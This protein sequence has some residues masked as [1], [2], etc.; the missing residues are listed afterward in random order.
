[1]TNNFNDNDLYQYPPFNQHYPD[2]IWNRDSEYLIPVISSVGNG[3]K[4]DKGDP[5]N[6]DDLTD[7]QLGKIYRAIGYRKLDGVYT[8][9]SVPAREIPIPVT[10]GY[11]PYDV[12]FVDVNGL[13]LVEGVDYSISGDNIVLANDDVITHVGTRVH[14]R[15][16]RFNWT[17][18]EF[19]KSARAYSTVAD[20]I[21]DEGL[22][23][24]SICHTNGFYSSGDGGASWYLVSS[25]ATE[26]GTDVIKLD[27]GLRAVLQPKEYITPEQLGVI[28][29]SDTIDSWDGSSYTYNQSTVVEYDEKIYVARV[30]VPQGVSINNHNYWVRCVNVEKLSGVVGDLSTEL[31]QEIE[32]REAAV[33][34]E[35]Q[36]RENAISEITEKMEADYS[37][38]SVLTANV[39]GEFDC[40]QGIGLDGHI[41]GICE[42]SNGDIV[43]IGSKINATNGEGFWRRVNIT[44][45]KD[46]YDSANYGLNIGHANSIAYN[47]KTNVCIVAPVNTTQNGSTV[48]VQ[49]I[50]E[51]DL[52]GNKIREI[53]T[54]SVF[55]GIAYDYVTE[56]LFGIDKEMHLY[57]ISDD[58]NFEF[59]KTLVANNFLNT[60]IQDFA[61]KGDL[62]IICDVWG[63]FA[64]YSLNENAIKHFYTI[65]NRN[66]MFGET[67]S[68]NFTSAGALIM[69]NALW[70][71][72][73]YIE[74]Y[75]LICE[76]ILDTNFYTE[77]YIMK[78]REFVGTFHINQKS[79]S[80]RTHKNLTVLNYLKYASGSINVTFDSDYSGL[81]W[82]QKFA[83]VNFNLN[84][85][86][87]TVYKEFYML[88]KV[89]ISGSG[90][91]DFGSLNIE[92]GIFNGRSLYL[93]GALNV[94]GDGSKS[95]L[96][97]NDSGIQMFYASA[98]VLFTGFTHIWTG[99]T[100]VNEQ[101]VFNAP[102][103]Q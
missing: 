62:I 5:L 96:M 59:V 33:E 98:N 6:F 74:E 42:V 53:Q 22:E 18:S 52:S 102:I 20:M 56:T 77:S 34:A 103:A 29:Y 57:S 32:N 1:M 76:I 37:N 95:I 93:T 54:P 17:E 13:D 97:S 11:Q 89:R 65:Y 41:G 85:Y 91:I 84:S 19:V 79:N 75:G 69:A 9:D 8:V 61:I 66:Y 49:Q 14:F 2:P 94:I 64:Q 88:N 36:A 45:N 23:A 3:P 83:N 4:G 72:K 51:Y 99:K 39:L 90:T 48:S 12:L 73:S 70:E 28:N 7:E 24:G 92:G 101:I 43:I 60:D 38:A 40:S 47:P 86:N 15:T 25:T 67:S 82:M 44:Q 55:F 31:G 26:T 35:T 46:Y 78:A 63:Q 71:E 27:N 16:L 80:L 50:W 81:Y 58:Y 30:D 87:W 100:L 10:D 68:I 21:Q